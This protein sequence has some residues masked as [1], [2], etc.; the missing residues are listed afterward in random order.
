VRMRGER[1]KKRINK[2]YMGGITVTQSRKD[3]IISTLQKYECEKRR[4]RDLMYEGRGEG[5]G[6]RREEN[7]DREGGT[8][9]YIVS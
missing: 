5:R 7:G 8:L 2:K 3:N 4:N 6:E 9:V 1:D